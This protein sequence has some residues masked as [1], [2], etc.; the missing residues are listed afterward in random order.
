MRVGP[1]QFDVRH[2][3]LTMIEL[4]VA[5]VILIIIMLAFGM[6][7]TTIQATVSTGQQTM[8]SNAAAAA[9]IDTLRGHVRQA[10]QH[11]FLAVTQTEHSDAPVL[12]LTTAGVIPSKTAAESSTG[13][14]VCVGM[15][16]NQAE[17]GSFDVLYCQSW[18]LSE[19]GSSDDILSFD[20]ANLQRF[21]RMAINEGIVRWVCDHCPGG[22]Q[23]DAGIR[24]PC[25]SLTDVN[26]LW[27]VLADN[28]EW[29]S[30]MW[31][32]GTTGLNGLVW[33]GVDYDQHSGSYVRRQKD[34][35]W[36][37]VD[38]PTW[39]A[40]AD[41]VEFNGDP[42]LGTPL[43]RALWTHHNQ[44]NWPRALKIKFKLEDH[45]NPY[46]VICPIGG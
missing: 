29:I 36:S 46:E 12:V 17:P 24:V 6:I 25:G 13:G 26:A 33:Y 22:P 14:L 30:I 2:A 9:I 15:C 35:N 43:Y 8:R 23:S 38:A 5:V 21:D 3:G 11:G 28:C 34:E 42:G 7:I 41:I 19:A 45:D 4:L 39:A 18:V 27:Q 16:E 1:G 44:N 40:D 32:D 20:L 37:T 10:T 31:T